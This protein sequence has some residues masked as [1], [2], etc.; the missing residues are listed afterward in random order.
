MMGN[1]SIGRPTSSKMSLFA[2]FL[3][4][5]QVM[6]GSARAQL[7]V[8]EKNPNYLTYNGDPIFLI[9]A[10]PDY[11]W[12]ILNT[13]LEFIRN[14]PSYG[15]NH[16]WVMLE[17][18][19]CVSW[20]YT[21][22]T[23]QGF[24]DKMRDIV[25][26][27]YENDIIVGISI[28]GYGIQKYYH[29]YS[30]NKECNHCD[31]VPGPL[32]MGQGFY[33]IHSNAAEIVEARN[34][35]KDILRRIVLATWK[36]P[37]VYYNP[38][39]ELNV[40]WTAQV[41]EWY[42]WVRDYM[43]SEGRK[44]DRNM[45]HLF[46]VENDMTLD[47][48]RAIGAD[49]IMEEDGNSEKCEG[50]PYVYW[51]MDGI[52]RGTSVWNGDLEPAYNLQYMRRAIYD[53]ASAGIASIWTTD[54]VEMDYMLQISEFMKTVDNFC[55]EPFQEIAETTLPYPNGQ[56]GVDLPGGQTCTDIDTT[57]P[58]ITGLYTASESKVH[59]LFSE[60][61]SLESANNKDNYAIEPEL[62]IVSAA[63]QDDEKTVIFT[64]SNH[65]RGLIYTLTVNGIQ[66]QAYSPNTIAENTTKYYTYVD[67]LV[68]YHITPVEYDTTRLG[69]GMSYYIDRP[70]VI[71]A[72]PEE[73]SGHL[74]IK[75]ANDDKVNT[76]ENFLRFY[77][78]MDVNLYVGYDVRIQNRPAWLQSWTNTGLSVKTNDTEFRIYSRVTPSGQVDLGG[79]GTSTSGSM[80]IVF[81]A[82]TYTDTEAPAPP[83][84]LVVSKP[85]G[86]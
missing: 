53:T 15:A 55:D 50:I 68:V 19:F 4:L 11:K 75:T 25:R 45:T 83:T 3:L 76:S 26:V 12:H 41:A 23:P 29:Y 13:D 47:E 73:F 62:I 43:I 60:K 6:A 64:T 57:P 27:A 58:E 22:Y 49:F 82:K 16:T 14:M 9:T 33:D 67:E 18:F 5:S 52:Y 65:Q 77:V 56:P 21:K 72:L 48:A 32:T 61:V 17:N 34:V 40:V 7:E 81:M 10:V 31:G 36:Y 79:N 51:S 69:V 78:T 44:I 1:K 80:Y 70:Y 28:F 24:Y 39:W 46:C 74:W 66:D 38:G 54:S 59:V 42:A 85:D 71:T 35:Q 84:G 30:F 86:S 63:L 20:N 8:Y 2:A 37:N